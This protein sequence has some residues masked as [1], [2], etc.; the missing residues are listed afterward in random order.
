MLKRKLKKI[1]DTLKQLFK[2][3]KNAKK[4][5]LCKECEVIEVEV[6]IDIGSVTCAY[7]VQR[8]VDPPASVQKA[9]KEMSEGKFPR[10]WALKTR[11]VHTDGRVFSKGKETDEIQTAPVKSKK[12]RVKKI[13]AKP[14]APKAK[15]T[16]K[17]RK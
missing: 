5:L 1:S 2:R 7:C 4:Y 6:G 11:Y 13:V 8:V 9:L 14:K 16:P 12:S 15:K 3:G 10:G 17:K